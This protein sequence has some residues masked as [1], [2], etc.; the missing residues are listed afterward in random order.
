MQDMHE[1]KNI[2]HLEE[3]ACETH[4]SVFWH[5]AATGTAPFAADLFRTDG[6]GLTMEAGRPRVLSTSWADH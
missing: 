4:R 6:K 3:G 1:N 5:A 2:T